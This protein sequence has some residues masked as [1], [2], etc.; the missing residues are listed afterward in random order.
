MLD[1]PGEVTLDQWELAPWLEHFWDHPLLDRDAST[2][3]LVDGVPATITILQTDR[4]TGRGTNNGTGT[5]REHRGR[6]LATLAK[7]ASLSRAAE[8]GIT[9]VYT[10]N[11]VTNAAMQAIN[12]KLGY[13]PRSTMLSWAKP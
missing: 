11:D 12:R 3:A 6:G 8:L 9:T 13:E 10:G 4:S 7:R 1:E 5:L 2:V